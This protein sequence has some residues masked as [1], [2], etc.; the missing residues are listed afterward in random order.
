MYPLGLGGTDSTLGSDVLVFSKYMVAKT[1]SFKPILGSFEWTPWS[2]CFKRDQQRGRKQ[3]A[4]PRLVCDFD[5][6][7]PTYYKFTQEVEND[8]A[9]TG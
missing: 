6:L 7:G 1:V 9:C 3:G 2:A 4:L 8:D 5:S